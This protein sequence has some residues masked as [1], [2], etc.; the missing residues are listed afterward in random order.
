MNIK[1]TE[2]LGL[3]IRLGE[4]QTQKKSIKEIIRKHEALQKGSLEAGEGS[5]VLAARKTIQTQ[6]EQLEKLSI[7]EDAI[8]KQIQKFTKNKAEAEKLKTQIE[9]LYNK[10]APKHVN[11]II[12]AQKK[13]SESLQRIDNIKSDI[14]NLASQ[15]RIL[16][17]ESIYYPDILVP[18]TLREFARQAMAGAPGGM[19]GHGMQKLEPFTYQKT[20][21]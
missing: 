11:E 8:T 4:I 13:I 21:R 14:E 7:E 15:Y 3:E 16:C 5:Q 12:R 19:L 6:Q 1:T 18:Q 10:Q 20:P 17:G 9:T 2:K